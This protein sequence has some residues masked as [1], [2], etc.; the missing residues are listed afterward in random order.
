MVRNLSYGRHA[1]G[2]RA[3]FFHLKSAGRAYTLHFYLLPRNGV[4]VELFSRAVGFPRALG[5]SVGQTL[6]RTAVDTE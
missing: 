4:A 1:D 5:R 6:T 2:P 3:V